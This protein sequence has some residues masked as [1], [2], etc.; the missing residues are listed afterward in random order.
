MSVTI[1]NNGYVDA[2]FFTGVKAV[3]VNR[4]ADGGYVFI[5]FS[6]NGDEEIFEVNSK[7]P[8]SFPVFVKHERIKA[9]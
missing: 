6:D 3:R 7:P 4:R 8:K 2:A 1:N 5:V 9:K